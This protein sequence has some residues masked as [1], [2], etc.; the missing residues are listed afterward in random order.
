MFLMHNSKFQDIFM[1][2]AIGRISKFSVIFSDLAHLSH[3]PVPKLRSQVYFPR[4]TTVISST[5]STPR[6]LSALTCALKVDSF[7]AAFINGSRTSV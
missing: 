5:S 6:S 7:S 3:S 4:N 1:D 2:T